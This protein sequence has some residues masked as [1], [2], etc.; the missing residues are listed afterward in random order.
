VTLQ[1]HIWK[2]FTAPRPVGRGTGM[3]LQVLASG[4]I[5]DVRIFNTETEL[6]FWLRFFHPWFLYF[7]KLNFK[8]KR[9]VRAYVSS[10]S[11]GSICEF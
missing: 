11:S 9:C 10:R 3:F 7:K 5:L 1:M 8:N 6:F 4:L 2:W